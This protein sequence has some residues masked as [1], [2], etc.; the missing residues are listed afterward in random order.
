MP[1]I[2]PDEALEDSEK[3]IMIAKDAVSGEAVVVRAYLDAIEAFG[4]DDVIAVAE[5]KHAT[6][7]LEPD[8]GIAVR[9]DDMGDDMGDSD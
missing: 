1:L 6:G 8:G 2:F 5:A 3:L 4:F 9:I 7:T